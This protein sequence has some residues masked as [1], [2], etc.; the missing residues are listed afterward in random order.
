MKISPNIS[1]RIQTNSNPLRDTIEQ[2]TSKN[3]FVESSSFEGIGYTQYDYNAPTRTAGIHADY[4][5]R[6]ELNDNEILEFE[7]L[8]YEQNKAKYINDYDGKYIVLQNGIVLDSDFSFS[9]LAKRVYTNF[10]YKAYFM[11][12]VSKEDKTYKVISPKRL[13]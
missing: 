12:L 11:P 8:L 9:E 5:N 4:K 6:M 3:Y 1:T 7:K 13:K 2:T 10:G